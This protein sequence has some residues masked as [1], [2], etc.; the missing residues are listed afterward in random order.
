MPDRESSEHT[1]FWDKKKLASFKERM[2]GLFQELLE[3]VESEYFSD[4]A[5]EEINARLNKD[6]LTL[7]DLIAIMSEA[8]EDMFDLI[9]LSEESADQAV[10]TL[11]EIKQEFGQ[12]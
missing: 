7:R 8:C 6:T 12:L 5:L 9:A 3:I 10:Y 4:W 1:Q 11:S 2:A